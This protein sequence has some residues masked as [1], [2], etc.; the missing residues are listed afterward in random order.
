MTR[1][2]HSSIAQK[3]RRAM[4]TI[5]ALAL[6]IASTGFITLEYFSYKEALNQRIQVLSEFIATNSTAA[7]S[8]DDE[9]TAKQLLNSLS[10]EKSIE[11]AILIRRDASLFTLYNKNNINLIESNS[12]L[13]NTINTTDVDIIYFIRKLESNR[14]SLEIFTLDKLISFKAISIDD[15]IL[16]LSLIHI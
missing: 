9:V 11:K 14:S 13:N 2:K 16:G 15:D 5:S 7:L 3:L 4:V 10:A 12:T 6:I 8:F 1:A